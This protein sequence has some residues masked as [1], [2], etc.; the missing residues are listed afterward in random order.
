MLIVPD[1]LAS[2]GKTFQKLIITISVLCLQFKLIL[3][4][5]WR[6]HNLA[7][8]N[9]LVGALAFSSTAQSMQDKYTL[10]PG[11]E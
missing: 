4:T 8:L 10:F 1:E 2:M 5:P 9:K 11:F 6:P 3:N 7:L